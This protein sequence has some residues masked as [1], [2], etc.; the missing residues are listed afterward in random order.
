VLV[1]LRARFDEAT[2][3]GLVKEFKK[4]GVKVLKGISDKKIH[5]KMT[6]IIRREGEDVTS[7]VHVGTGNYNP[8]TARIYT[9][10]SLLTT[11]TSFGRD[12]EKLF[13]SF[14][15]GRLPRLFEV[16]VPAPE[17]LHKKLTQWVRGEARRALEGD[18][19]ARIVAKMNS[20][21]DPKM[22]EEL[23]AASRAGV[24]IDLIVRG[25]CVLRPG[26]AGV[27]ENIRV[28]S[29]VDKYLEHSR[30]YYF[31]NGDQP[32]VY[33]SSADWMPRSFHKRVEVAFPVEEF[34]LKNYVRDFVLETYLKDNVK[35]RELMPDGRWL[36]KKP[37]EG[38]AVFHAQEY[39]E[40]LAKSRYKGTPLSGRFIK[41]GGDKS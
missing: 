20:L 19:D 4:N 1:E 39:F 8:A 17:Q 22:C 33:L 10:L 2:N 13:K 30:I 37:K 36:R 5:C 24:K 14:E 28:I 35:A 3:I 34:E 18:K 41:Y 25:A 6:Q 23:Y 9:D 29:I 7:V 38:E 26:V 11:S 16:F 40:K 31:K 12:V 21:V 27:S 32:L 15:S